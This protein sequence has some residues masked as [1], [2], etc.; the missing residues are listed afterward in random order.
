MFSLQIVIIHGK[1]A[2]HCT[3]GNGVHSDTMGKLREVDHRAEEMQF[4][5]CWPSFPAGSLRTN[6]FRSGRGNSIGPIERIIY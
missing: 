1:G 4:Q 5:R 3:L 2:E 6:S